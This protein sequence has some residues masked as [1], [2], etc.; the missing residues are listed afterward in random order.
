MVEDNTPAARSC[1]CYSRVTTQCYTRLSRRRALSNDARSHAVVALAL[2]GR[3]VP[4]RGRPERLAF[5]GCFGSLRHEWSARITQLEVRRRFRGDLV[6]SC[7]PTPVIRFNSVRRRASGAAITMH[8]PQNQAASSARGNEPT[9]ETI[10]RAVLDTHPTLTY[11]SVAA[12]TE[13]QR[14]FSLADAWIGANTGRFG[15]TRIL[16]SLG[17]SRI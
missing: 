1:A 12:L 17:W 10:A 2:R 5:T 11:C 13:K 9:L 8:R 7:T 6:E 15:S 3:S 4:R 14:N 16:S